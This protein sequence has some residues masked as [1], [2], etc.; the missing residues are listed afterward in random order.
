VA[1]VLIAGVAVLSSSP[2]AAALAKKKNP[3]SKVFVADLKGDSHV[4]NGERIEA[5]TKKSVFSAEGTTIETKPDSTDSLV[6]S[7]GT[8]VFVAPETRFEVKKF[9]Q[10][11]FSPNRTDLDAEPS[12][13]QTLLRMSRGALGICTSKLVAGSSMTC[14]TPHATI[15]I[16][17]RKVMVEIV[18]EETR[19]SLLEGDVTVIGNPSTSGQTLRPGQQAIIRRASVDQEPFVSVQ[20]IPEESL[21]K[22][23][24]NVSLAC[25]SR[26]TVYFEVVDRGDGTTPFDGEEAG[27]IRPVEITPTAP[28]TPFTVSPARIDG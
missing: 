7:N 1:A 10:E 14:V 22:I 5:L 28:P 3:T 4:D 27:E 12:I 20:P 17:G 2:V 24:E 19:V 8:A 13:S 9:L 6:F 15:N 16:R 21:A 26:R 25:L 18:G 23:D 11:P